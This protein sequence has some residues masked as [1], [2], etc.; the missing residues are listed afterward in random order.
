[1][2]FFYPRSSK[3]Y[4]S[5]GQQAKK[6]YLVQVK[7]NR[8]FSLYGLKIWLDLTLAQTTLAHGCLGPYIRANFSLGPISFWPQSHFGQSDF[9]P[10][11][12][13]PWTLGPKDILAL[14]YYGP[15]TFGPMDVRAH[16]P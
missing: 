8:I 11:Q 10:G 13:G 6:S 4:K 7:K 2:P 16:G 3:N 9:G 1:M 15:L 5:K 14:A 12:F